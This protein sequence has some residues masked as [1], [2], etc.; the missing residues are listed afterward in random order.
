MPLKYFFLACG[1]AGLFI[2][3]RVRAADSAAGV[4]LKQLDDRVRVEI[5][6]Q[7]FTEYFFKDV[8][9]PYCYPVL[10]PNEVP[11]TRNFP[12]KSTEGE[13]HD[14]KHHRSLWFAYGEINGV[15]FWSEDKAFG[16]T[17]HEKF[18][19]VKGGLKSGV[20]QSQNK[21]VAADGKVVCTD[22]RTLRFY[23]SLNPRMLDFEITIHASNGDVTFGDTKEGMMSVRI[24]ESMRLSHGKKPG[25]GHIV[26]SEGVTDGQTWGKRAA[27]VDYYGPVNGQTVGI[28][29]FDHPG[30]LRHP[31]WWHVRDYG[32]FG[33]NPFGLHDF[34][35]K[36]PGAGNHLLKS[37]E[38]LTFRY[39]LLFHEGDEKGAKIAQRYREYSAEPSTS[40]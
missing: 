30:N 25:E 4:Q 15:D 39:R 20:L 6:G 2:P 3:D 1:L 26:N 35:K 8:P 21:W 11:M 28:A 38:S 36:P 34:E 40:K 19:A 33:A 27:W 37:G 29:M 14:H 17:V 18:T 22:D 31:T 23:N 12:M 10:G 7:L 9:R 5:G 13:D 16:K 32:L 24:A